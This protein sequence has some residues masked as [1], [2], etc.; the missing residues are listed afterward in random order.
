M[1]CCFG[2]HSNYELDL[3]ERGQYQC[4]MLAKMKDHETF[5]VESLFAFV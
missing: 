2:A 3:R 4:A 1:G 5:L